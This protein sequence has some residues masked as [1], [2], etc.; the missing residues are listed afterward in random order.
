MSSHERPRESRSKVGLRIYSSGRDQRAYHPGGL[1]VV[2]LQQPGPCP[3][4]FGATAI[5]PARGGGGPAS[6]AAGPRRTALKTV[7]KI[8]Q[9]DLAR[10]ARRP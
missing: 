4:R 6:T 9:R 2:L 8:G 7:Q 1:G 3:R 10:L 5:L